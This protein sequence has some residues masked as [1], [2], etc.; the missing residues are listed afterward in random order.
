MKVKNDHR[1]KFPILSNWKEAWKKSGLQRDSSLGSLRYRCDALSTRSIYWV[2]ISREEW[3][4]VKYIWN[5]FSILTRSS[6]VIYFIYSS[7]H[8]TPHG[9]NELNKLT[10]LEMCGSF[11]HCLQCILTDPPLAAQYKLVN[12]HGALKDAIIAAT[13]VLLKNS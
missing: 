5:K 6:N 13:R 10:S 3:N 11:L 1:S 2:H 4:D 7:H 12:T 9:R 8:F